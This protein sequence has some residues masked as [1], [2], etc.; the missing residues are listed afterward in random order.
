M[1]QVQWKSLENIEKQ[2]VGT[3]KKGPQC[4]AILLFFFLNALEVH[5][6]HFLLRWNFPTR[7]LSLVR[8][9]PSVSNDVNHGLRTHEGL[10]SDKTVSRLAH[11]RFSQKMNER[12]WF[13]LP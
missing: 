7:F 1:Q 9:R 4:S 10:R 13:F 8:L 3:I 12:I 5:Q 11:R 2:R 6:Q